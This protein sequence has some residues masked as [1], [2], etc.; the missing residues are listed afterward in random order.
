MRKKRSKDSVGSTS[1]LMAF[2]FVAVAEEMSAVF[3]S[4][5]EL[6]LSGVGARGLREQEQRQEGDG[7]RD[8]DPDLGPVTD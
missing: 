3:G 7:A 8:R 4:S 2:S 1:E 6:S 5:D